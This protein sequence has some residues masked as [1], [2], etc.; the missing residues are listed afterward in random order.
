MPS[1]N[2]SRHAG[3][4]PSLTFFGFVQ[5]L[6]AK[7][8]VVSA[9][10]LRPLFVQFVI[11]MSALFQAFDCGYTSGTIMNTAKFTLERGHESREGLE[12]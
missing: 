3:C 6:Q 4:L 8:G 1:S 7:T 5:S 2:V 9:G 12:V 11:K 10:W